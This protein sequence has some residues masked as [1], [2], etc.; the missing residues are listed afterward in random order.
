MNTRLQVEHPVTEAVTGLDLV[1]LQLLVAAGAP[2]PFA[3]EEVALR[4]HAIECRVY[5]EDAAA[6][7]LPLAA[8]WPLRAAD[9]AGHPQR[10]GCRHRR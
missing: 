7:F 3:Q 10:C 9:G 4:G 8:H 2:L 6:G 1:R 5:A